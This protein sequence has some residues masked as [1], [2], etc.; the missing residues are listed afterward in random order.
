MIKILTTII[1]IAV[2]LNQAAAQN[3]SK[4]QWVTV[5]KTALPAALCNSAQYFRQCFDVTAIE[6][7]EAAASTTRICLADLVSN[8]P[9]IL[10]QPKDG[11]HWG[12]KVGECAGNAYEV[13]LIKKRIS[14][15]KCNNISNWQ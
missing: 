7:K 15:A 5:M 13:S 14:S 12:S 3:V 11:T 9:D 2:S 8:I 4:D 6:C 10:V 1:F